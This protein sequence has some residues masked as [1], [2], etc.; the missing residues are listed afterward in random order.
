[1]EEAANILYIV[2]RRGVRR[3]NNTFARLLHKCTRAKYM[4]ESKKPDMFPRKSHVKMHGN[5]GGLESSRHFFVENCERSVV[6]WTEMIAGYARKGHSEEALKLFYQMRREGMEPNQFTFSTV[7]KP[8]ASLVALEQG[9]QIHADVIKY[10]FESNIFIASNLLV[11][12][13]KCNTVEDARE[14]F[15]EMSVRDVVS[16]SAMIAGFA[17]NGDWEEALKLLRQMI[18]GGM[19][20]NDFTIASAL[21]ACAGLAALEQGKCVHALIMAIGFDSDVFVGSA[22]VDMYA[23]C[24]CVEDARHVFEEIPERDVVAWNAMITGYAQNGLGEKAVELFCKMKLTGIKPSEFAFASVLKA[25]ASLATL[26]QGKLIHGEV[27]KFGYVSDVFVGSAIVDMYAKCESMDD[28]H[29]VFC[30]MSKRNVVSCN[31]M[32]AGY[33][34]YGHAVEALK[35]FSQMLWLSMKPDLF[36]FT[37]ILAACPI[38]ATPDQGRQVH[39]HT[40]KIGFDSDVSVG[41]ALVGMYWKCGSMNDACK[42]FDNMAGQNAVSRTAMI[43]GYTQ[44]GLGEEALKFFCQM[45][46]VGSKLDQFTFSS[47]LRACATLAAMEQ[48]NRIYACIIKN[49]FESDVFV[50]SSLVDMYSKCGRIEDACKIFDTM[51]ERNVVSWNAMITGYA[52]HGLGKQAIELFEQMQQ[53]GIKPS[54]I[55]FIGVLFACSHVGLVAEGFHYFDIM[56]QDYGITPSVEHYTCMVDLLGRAGHLLEAESFIY[57]MPFEPGAVVWRALLGACRVHGNMELGKRAA[58]YSI[59]LEP[60]EAATYVLLSNIYASA[61]RWDDV[62]KVR[63]MMKDQGVIKEP[64]R[65]WIEVKNRVHEFIAEDRSH[66]RKEEIYAMLEILIGQMKMAGYVPDTK[67]VLHDLEPEQKEPYLRYH[68]EKL[69][70]AFGLISTPMGAPIRIVKNLRVC[71]DCH[72]AAKFVSTIVQREIVVRDMN[73]FHHFKDGQCSCGD[74]W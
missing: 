18:A 62:V 68:S 19:K 17:H 35:L 9:K 24:G 25:C 37:S 8:C 50:G 40:V 63:N 70:I 74:Y 4:V 49:G 57:K 16:W 64:G 45:Q 67:F 51:H 59:K 23:K 66:P 61:G 52:Q 53:A 73:R 21:T 38:L 56:S 42:V 60:Q 15:D 44:N 29:T 3:D 30:K 54:H 10:G 71:G 34:Q 72:T 47:A 48:G 7:L 20:P 14:V 2:C 41:N 12:Y 43:A 22:L 13:A 1:M 58:E 26:E 27:I 69:A 39:A 33:A 46:S 11:M 55:T 36:T 32:I 6:M 5:C 31:T 65:S 28:A